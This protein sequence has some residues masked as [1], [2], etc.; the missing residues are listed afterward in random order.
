MAACKAGFVARMNHL[1][2]HTIFSFS[3]HAFDT[4]SQSYVRMIG[5]CARHSTLLSDQSFVLITLTPK[6]LNQITANEP[7]R[8]DHIDM[9]DLI[10]YTHKIRSKHKQNS[11]LPSYH[12]FKNVFYKSVE[13]LNNCN[14]LQQQIFNHAISID[15]IERLLNSVDMHQNKHIFKCITRSLSQNALLLGDFNS[16]GKIVYVLAQITMKYEHEDIHYDA[17]WKKLLHVID[18]YNVHHHMNNLSL[19][20]LCFGLSII[21]NRDMNSPINTLNITT[22]ILEY[23][24][25]NIDLNSLKGNQIEHLIQGLI[26]SNTFLT[27]FCT[28]F[29]DK[30]TIKLYTFDDLIAVLAGMH[31]VTDYDVFTKRINTFLTVNEANKGLF[32]DAVK[33]ID[34]QLYEMMLHKSIKP[35]HKSIA[36]LFKSLSY[37]H[38]DDMNLIH[39]MDKNIILK[40]NPKKSAHKNELLSAC[41]WCHAVNDVPFEDNRVFEKCVRGLMINGSDEENEMDDL[42]RVGYGIVMIYANQ[43]VCKQHDAI[44][45]ELM[46]QFYRYFSSKL[47]D[48]K[49]TRYDRYIG[50]ILRCNLGLKLLD[51]DIELLDE[52]MIHDLENKYEEESNYKGSRIEKILIDYLH[53]EYKQNEIWIDAIDEIKRNV[54]LDNK[55]IECDIVIYLKDEKKKDVIVDVLGSHHYL[56]LSHRECGKT[57]FLQ[58]VWNKMDYNVYK[59]NVTDFDKIN[60]SQII[61]NVEKLLL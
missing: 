35:N 14:T 30:N 49:H 10:L 32:I 51:F 6:Q 55:V 3:Q 52:G 1:W 18:R 13:T 50:S 9:V 45:I 39:F 54:V 15:T 36:S 43:L 28:H 8:I 57:K 34:N 61:K 37:G 44:N 29:A 19:A 17:M 20:Y 60:I 7:E 38:F 16:Y 56:T 5:R 58:W 42:I 46:T 2:Y 11:H 59:V 25:H 21:K 40:V 24:E 22:K 26:H 48:I 27:K 47:N 53:T 41:L 33:N 4:Q 12:Y 23:V 31:F